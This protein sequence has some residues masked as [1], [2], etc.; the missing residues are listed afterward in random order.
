MRIGSSR[1]QEVPDGPAGRA[2]RMERS[3][4]SQFGDIG[5]RLKA[6][7]DDTGQIPGRAPV[8]STVRRR[9]FPALPPAGRSYPY[10]PKVGRATGGCTPNARVDRYGRSGPISD[11]FACS[12]AT[13]LQPDAA[14]RRRRT[15]AQ[16]DELDGASL[17]V[18]LAKGIAGDHG[19]SSKAVR[20]RGRN[21]RKSRWLR[22]AMAESPSRS[23]TTTTE[24]STSPDPRLPAR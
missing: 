24:A 15:T 19:I 9:S 10:A 6:R 8:P 12:P 18:G 11:P 13:Q 20:W 22:V 21:T 5:R 14:G 4:V 2:V 23:A 3:A 17:A 7:F 1:S 16:A